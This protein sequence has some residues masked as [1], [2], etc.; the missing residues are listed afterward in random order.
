VHLFDIDIPGKIKFR[1]SDVLTGGDTTTLV[2]TPFGKIG[3]GICYDVRFPELAMIAAR[4][5]AAL[6]IYP[7]AF[8]MTTGPLHWE[9]L[10]RARA[11]D[12]Q[13]YV[14][15]CSPA[16]YPE[17][18]GYVAFGESLVVDPNGEVVGRAG[19]GEEM[20]VVDVRR[21]RVEGTRKGIPVGAQRR[22]DVYADV[23]RAAPQEPAE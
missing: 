21:E 18:G 16:R 14:A 3:V 23:A 12:N 19:A 11:V 8:N 15:M 2:S 13:I 20:V 4:R 22:W 6:M 10:A 9:L 7:G 17:G 5:G 1:E